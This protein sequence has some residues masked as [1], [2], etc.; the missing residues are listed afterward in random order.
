MILGVGLRVVW[1]HSDR[2]ST[3][4]PYSLL[5]IVLL[6]SD[7]GNVAMILAA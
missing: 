7:A 5:L 1:W 6:H 3:H 2:L 4:R